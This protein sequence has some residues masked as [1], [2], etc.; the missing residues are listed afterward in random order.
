[1][2]EEGLCEDL[3]GEM[4]GGKHPS[5]WSSE[6]VIQNDGRA[7]NGYQNFISTAARTS[8]VDMQ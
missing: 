8:H 3:F 5:G 4:V 6:R 1:M 2:L 7:V